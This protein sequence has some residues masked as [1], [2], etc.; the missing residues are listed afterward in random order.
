MVTETMGDGQILFWRHQIPKERS[1]NDGTMTSEKSLGLINRIQLKTAPDV[2]L[3]TRLK[4]AAHSLNIELTHTHTH[5]TVKYVFINQMLVL[6]VTVAQILFLLNIFLFFP[7]CVHLI[8]IPISST[9]IRSF[10]LI[11]GISQL[12][13]SSTR[14]SKYFCNF[15]WLIRLIQ[16][17]YFDFFRKLS[18]LNSSCKPTFLFLSELLNRLLL[19]FWILLQLD[20]VIFTCTEKARTDRLRNWSFVYNSHLFIQY[21]SQSQQ[22]DYTFPIKNVH[23]LKFN[24]LKLIKI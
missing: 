20:L 8:F 22:N 10:Q 15:S 23:T 7:V 21:I 6:W 24:K 4:K 13:V 1:R 17:I 16:Q 9:I 14:Y 11:S 5:K 2:Y 3:E 18:K 12:L 19:T